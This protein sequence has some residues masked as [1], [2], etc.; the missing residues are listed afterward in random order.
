MSVFRVGEHLVGPGE[1][2]L[3]QRWVDGASD[4]D[5]ISALRA[6]ARISSSPYACD[7]G[8]KEFESAEAFWLHVEHCE[9]E[10]EIADATAERKQ[11]LS[12][13]RRREFAQVRAQ[14][15]LALINRDGY[16]CDILSAMPRRT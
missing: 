15:E 6:L 4:G 7:M 8:Y 9:R 5:M 1:I 11:T 16:V 13:T 2:L 14:V 3:T 10:K 12:R